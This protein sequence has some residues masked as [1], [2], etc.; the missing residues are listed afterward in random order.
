MDRSISLSYV[1]RFKEKT[2]AE[3]EVYLQL[4]YVVPNQ[5]VFFDQSK[6]YKLNQSEMIVINSQYCR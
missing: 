2:P 6:Q 1:Y 5:V 3:T 4:S